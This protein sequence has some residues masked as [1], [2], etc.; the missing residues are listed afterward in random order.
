MATEQRASGAAPNT[1]R[2]AEWPLGP[3]ERRSV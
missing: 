3:V 2:I 1:P